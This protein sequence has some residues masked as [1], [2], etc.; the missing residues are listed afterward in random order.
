MQIIKGFHSRWDVFG[1]LCWWPLPILVLGVFC[2]GIDSMTS[3]CSVVMSQS[4]NKSTGRFFEGAMRLC[5]TL[6]P[7][8][9]QARLK[10]AAGHASHIPGTTG[11]LSV[12][13]QGLLVHVLDKCP[14]PH[15]FLFQVLG[16]PA[17]NLLF[18]FNLVFTEACTFSLST[19]CSLLLL[20]LF[21]SSCFFC[22]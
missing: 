4:V 15:G 21:L 7:L 18:P 20:K 3:L 5:D 17:D 12:G 11:H 16:C 8:E 9:C 10:G 22:L 2:R 19:L 1:A 14:P 13:V 6:G